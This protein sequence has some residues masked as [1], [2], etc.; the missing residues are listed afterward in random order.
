MADPECFYGATWGKGA[1]TAVKARKAHIPLK[2][3]GPLLH[4][5]LASNYT[6][7]TDV[8]R[9]NSEMSVHSMKVALLPSLLQ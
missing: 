7:S 3:C 5:Q 6:G 2:Q 4:I 1:C 8:P 9:V